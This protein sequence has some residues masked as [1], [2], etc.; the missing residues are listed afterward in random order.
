MRA[1]VEMWL[2]PQLTYA[3]YPLKRWYREV[4]EGRLPTRFCDFYGIAQAS[5][6]RPRHDNCL[7]GVL[8]NGE[9]SLRKNGYAYLYKV[10]K[11]PHLF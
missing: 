11:L 7:P 3:E 4:A 6:F 9:S 1:Q 2:R 5:N 10:A 8:G